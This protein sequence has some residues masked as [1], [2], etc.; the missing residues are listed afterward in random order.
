M[1]EAKAS[2]ENSENEGKAKD[3]L[4]EDAEE[5]PKKKHHTKLHD[6]SQVKNVLKK[7]KKDAKTPDIKDDD[8]IGF[9]IHS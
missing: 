1:K 4:E 3:M 8:K 5:V 6:L 9:K 2:L 7:I